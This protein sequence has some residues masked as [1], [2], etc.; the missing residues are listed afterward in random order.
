[1]LE[2]PKGMATRLGV[3]GD[4]QLV[5][6]KVGGGQRGQV[7]GGSEVGGEIEVGEGGTALYRNY[8]V[9]RNGPLGVDHGRRFTRVAHGVAD[10]P[11]QH[12]GHRGHHERPALHGLAHDGQRLFRVGIHQWF[13]SDLGDGLPSRAVLLPQDCRHEGAICAHVGRR[14]FGELLSATSSG[15]L[16][17]QG[18]TQGVLE[19]QDRRAQNRRGLMG[20]HLQQAPLVVAVEGPS[21]PRHGERDDQAYQ[22]HDR[23]R[24]GRAQPPW[25][26]GRGDSGLFAGPGADRPFHRC[27][28]GTAPSRLADADELG[29]DWIRPRWWQLGGRA[30]W[31]LPSFTLPAT[32][33][34]QPSLR[35]VHPLADD[36]DSSD[37]NYVSHRR[38]GVAILY[39]SA[40]PARERFGPG[41]IRHGPPEQCG[42]G[43]MTYLIPRGDQA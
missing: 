33:P 22:Y 40:F 43:P 41:A 23:G 21:R 11:G 35:R 1:M 36:A 8:P 13:G 26:G 30:A 28:A 5:E 4:R 37:G 20:L 38:T 39:E 34:F 6:R 32:S 9:G 17:L 24:P 19:G 10:P 7:R 18:R 25:T 15:R 3:T 27:H 31:S 29:T 2:S 42:G 14:E 12:G 16:D